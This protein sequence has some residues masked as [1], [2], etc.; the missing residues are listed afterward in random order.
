MT[1]PATALH[2]E[3]VP[4]RTG[5]APHPCLVMLHGLGADEQDLLSLAGL[6]DPRLLVVSIRAPFSYGPG[7]AWYNLRQI[8][9]LDLG[10]FHHSLDLLQR[11]MAN[12]PHQF[13][14][15]AQ[16][17]YGLGFSQG[18]MMTGSLR[19]LEPTSSTGSILLSGYLP[20]SQSLAFKASELPGAPFFIAHGSYD[21]VVALEY[22]RQARDYLEWAGAAVAYHEYSMSHQIIG[23][24]IR[25]LNS[26]LQTQLKLHGT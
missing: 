20:L 6:L 2:F 24:E 22:G 9:D 23:P 15:D 16:H 13:P 10:T 1:I 17:I 25:E 18:A 26:W 5:A 14:V 4:P 19:L 8:D 12:V 7:Y 3:V 11:F 21:D